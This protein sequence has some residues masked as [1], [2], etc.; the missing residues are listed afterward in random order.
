MEYAPAIVAAAFVAFGLAS[1]VLGHSPV[2]GAMVF[3]ATGLV[4]GPEV[5]DLADIGERQDFVPLLLEL[6]LTIVLFTDASAINSSRWREEAAI[7][8][9]LLAIG[10]PLAILAGWGLALLVLGELEFFEAAVLA[11][12]L[13][14]TDA[15]LGK[16][17]VANPRVPERIRQALNV[18][19]GLNDGLALPLFAVFLEAARAAERSL[20]ASDVVAEL[21]S[22]VGVAVVVGVAVGWLGA[23]GFRLAIGHRWAT[24][25]WLQVSMAALAVLAFA[26]ADPLGGSGF[27][28]AWV[29]GV[30]FGRARR[31]SDDDLHEFAEES[32][33][34]LTMLSFLV[35]GLALGPVLVEATWEMAL[36]GVASLTAVRMVAVALALLGSG[37][38]APSV[39]YVGWFGPRGLA[40]LI[41]TLS[42]VEAT[43]LTGAVTISD[44]ALV[45]VALSVVLHGAT[46][47]WGSNAY[48]DWVE[49]HPDQGD[50]EEEQLVPTVRVPHRAHHA[51]RV[52]PRP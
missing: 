40:T 9:R 34:T 23:R 8:G 10:L 16:A 6:T 50:L 36:Y 17:V 27:I 25:Y 43:E 12:M 32:G 47:W 11:T 52:P 33:D 30:T 3:T 7:P 44:T 24:D 49:A 22:E 41:L 42:V 37:L 20:S 26:L 2:S 39:L 51:R 5:L 38:R 48:A 29:A 18:E 21:V 14:P 15:A 35:F 4:L 45:T 28:A 19:S 1:R 46:A 13:V 31:S